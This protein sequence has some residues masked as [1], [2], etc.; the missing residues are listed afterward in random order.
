MNSRLVDRL[1]SLID[2]VMH[3]VLYATALLTVCSPLMW[4]Y[5]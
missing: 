3:G 2:R 5:G 4:T 1:V